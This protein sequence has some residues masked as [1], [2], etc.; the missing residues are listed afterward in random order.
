[1]TVDRERAGTRKGS[2]KYAALSKQDQMFWTAALAAITNNPRLRG[3]AVLYLTTRPAPEI[4]AVIV[5]VA[6]RGRGRVWA[7]TLVFT[8]EQLDLAYEP[9]QMM[10]IDFARLFGRAGSDFSKEATK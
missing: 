9:G 4:N 3:K 1:M 6:L 10:L 8:R 2:T 5:H 7:G